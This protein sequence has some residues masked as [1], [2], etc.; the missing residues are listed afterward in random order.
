MAGPALFTH[1]SLLDAPCL[2]PGSDL[3]PSLSLPPVYP[4]PRAPGLWPPHPWGSDA[5]PVVGGG[6]QTLP[7][8]LCLACIRRLPAQDPRHAP[9]A[10]RVLIWLS[11]P[12]PRAW[13][14]RLPVPIILG[15]TA[16]RL[17]G[18]GLSTPLLPA[19]P[20]GRRRAAPTPHLRTPRNVPGPWVL[21]S[22]E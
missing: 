6:A 1:L 9:K 3:P 5:P 21:L 22:L 13:G 20:G 11:S 10:L 19:G 12:S 8:H 2:V 15:R 18:C 7:L 16:G 14:S 17:A 4:T